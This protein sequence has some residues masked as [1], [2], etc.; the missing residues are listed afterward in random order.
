MTKDD[1]DFPFGVLRVSK[2]INFENNESTETGRY[3]TSLI[4]CK[5]TETVIMGNA[6]FLN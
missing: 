5:Y 4:T 6:F 3:P 1:P 2:D